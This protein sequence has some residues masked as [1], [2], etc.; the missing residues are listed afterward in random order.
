[1]KRRNFIKAGAIGSAGVAVTALS[2]PVIASGKR[3]FTLASFV[4]KMFPGLGE[5]TMN[6]VNAVKA[7]TDG[8]ITIKLYGA[9]ELVGALE[10]FDAASDGTVD[11][12]STAAFY[13]QGK[14]QALPFLTTV[15]FGMS[16]IEQSAYLLSPQGKKRVT[17]ICDKFNLVPLLGTCTGIQAGGWFRKE[18]NSVEDFK[19]LRVRMPGL[20]GEIF[21][22]LGASP[23]TIPGGEIFQALQSGTIDASEWA[24]PWNDIL[25]GL[26]KV[27]PYYYNPGI[28]EPASVLHHFFNKDT[29]ASLSTSDQ[30]LIEAVSDSE[31]LKGMAQYHEKNGVFLQKL[32]ESKKVKFS[33]YDDSIYQ[34]MA[35]AAK[36][37]YAELADSGDDLTKA[38][39]QEYFAFQKNIGAWTNIAD[40]Y[41]VNMRTRLF[42]A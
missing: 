10:S 36:E 28:H 18:M 39:L 21:K 30:R 17:E 26:Y 5:H 38:T 35:K 13:Y 2:T 37:V 4:P 31:Y 41:Y 19:G 16:A 24:G 42:D 3:E 33:R 9:G 40:S 7:V 8:R 15:P 29:W 32:E 1:M 25:M 27:A 6:F 12:G 34:A 20:G 14:S 23:V 22:K 11:I